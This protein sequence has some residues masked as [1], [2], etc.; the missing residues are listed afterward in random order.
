[1][2]EAAL[3]KIATE[4]LKP[5]SSVIDALL[6]PKIQRIKNWAEK[7]DLDSRL[8]NGVIDVLLDR[9]MRRLLRR[10]CGI[11]T[12]VFPQRV[13]PLTSIY[14][15]L[16]L[17]EGHIQLTPNELA[18]FGIGELEKGLNYYIVDSAGMGK[19][20]FAK[21]L[22]LE[23]LASTNKIPLFLELRRI[24]ENETLLGKLASEIDESKKDVDERLLPLLLKESEFVLIL[25][26]YDEVP[27][28]IRKSLGEQ[29]TQLAI[30]CENLQLIVT[31][32]PEVS[33]PELPDSRVLTIDPL[34]KQQAES[35][36]LRYD[37]VANI[38]VGRKLAAQFD[39]VSEQ[40]LR[41]PLL[42]VLLYRTYGFNQSI[43]TRI[44][45][46]YDE[47]FNALYKGHDLSKAGF[48][49]EKFSKLDSE[50]FRRLLR[51]FSFLLAARQKDN[52]NSRT[53]GVAVVNEAVQLT[54][55]QPSSAS[56]FFDDLLLAVPFLVREGTEYR[57]IHRSLGEFFAAEFLAYQP[58]SERVIQHIRDGN[59]Y[60]SFL[61]TFQFLSEINPSLFRR[62]IVAPIAK[63]V[64][65]TPIDNPHVR[66]MRFLSPT[67]ITVWPAVGV[68]RR[69]FK[70]NARVPM[71]EGFSAQSLLYGRIKGRLYALVVMFKH[72]LLALPDAAFQTIS[73]LR[74]NSYDIDLEYDFDFLENV[75]GD[76]EWIP[77]EDERILNIAE[78]PI[79]TEM[80]LRANRFACTFTTGDFESKRI[81]TVRACEDLLEQIRKEDDTHD[82]LETIVATPHKP[83]APS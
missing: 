69:D 46:F 11:T 25:D 66:A 79:I 74:E 12:I 58:N 41:T 29:V 20:T 72:S 26:G 5:V 50:D 31:A 28:Q 78:Q 71:V 13:L 55:V 24:G 77:I 22:V 7:R 36:V 14:E 16:T 38:N 52:L 56:A 60:K 6:G 83:D 27:E 37:A 30:Q 39:V 40:F 18:P 63:R 9:H 59:L 44:S 54:S 4:A 53:E 82:W 64:V 21:H 32:R 33:L 1:M 81:I 19:S 34:S 67:L 42:V 2:S 3:T 49:R 15:P 80:M 47:V 57:F 75:I 35:L 73:E 8:G 51:G 70:S 43:A 62:L 65:E 61:N 48:A 10:T 68:S 23:I 17:K 76:K 45:S